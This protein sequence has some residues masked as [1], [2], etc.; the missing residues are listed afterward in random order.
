MENVEQITLSKELSR[1]IRRH[2]VM[3]YNYI[4]A[5]SFPK[6]YL[7]KEDAIRE[8]KKRYKLLVEEGYLAYKKHPDKDGILRWRDK[9]VE[10]LYDLEALSHTDFDILRGMLPAEW[11]HRPITTINDQTIKLQEV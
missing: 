10:L 8:Y 4:W 11:D 6:T 9:L 3:D 7:N 1:L 2:N 5:G